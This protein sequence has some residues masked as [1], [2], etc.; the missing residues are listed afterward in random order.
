MAHGP[1]AGP[2]G[3]L[4]PAKERVQ[5]YRPILNLARIECSDLQVL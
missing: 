3:T 5:Q 4:I 1:K 2:Y